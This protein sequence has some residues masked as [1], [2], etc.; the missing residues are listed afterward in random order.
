LLILY[1]KK[2]DNMPRRRQRVPTE[3]FDNYVLKDCERKYPSMD[4]LTPAQ[5]AELEKRVYKLMDLENNARVPF[6][7]ADY[8]ARWLSGKAGFE[9]RVL[10]DEPEEGDRKKKYFF[11]DPFDGDSMVIIKEGE[12]PI[13]QGFNLVACHSDA[14]CLRIK[15]SPIKIEW[16]EDEQ[17]F[18]LGVRLSSAAHGGLVYSQWPSQQVNL[19]GYFVDEK[20]NRQVI[21]IPGIIPD[22]S[23][24][25][26]HRE[27]EEVEDAFAPEETLEV[28]LGHTTLKETLDRFGFK[29]IDDFGFAKI[30]G[31]PTNMAL[32]ID[33][34][35]WR[36]LCA[37]GHDDRAC[38]FSAVS[39]I[40]K[41]RNPKLTSIVWIGDNEEVGDVSPSG[42]NGFVM[43]LVLD[44]LLRKHERNTGENI[45][46]RDRRRLLLMSSYLYADVNIAPFGK[47]STKMDAINAPKLGFGV[48]IGTAPGDVSSLYFARKLKNIALQGK[49]RGN[50]ICPQ[51]VGNM[52]HQNLQDTWAYDQFGGAFLNQI[53]QWN[54]SIG[55][56]CASTHSPNEVICPGDEYAL[57][58]FLTRF[59]RS[60]TGLEARVRN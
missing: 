24:H 40:S 18:T 46:E 37:Y 17:Y 26:D 10:L 6:Q 4:C 45:S 43:D 13:T 59:F 9:E 47:D 34:K 54:T 16:N 12:L 32:P 25:T 56:P 49:A 42:A 44:Y 15:P 19:I 51:V 55:I 39:A 38:M 3:T 20:F 1:T 52:Y 2:V 60:N 28:I 31:V 27:G 53:G 33:E 8:N 36:L 23:A 57:F 35:T 29:S 50:N 14:P 11:R 41:V 22:I 58:Q 7:V 21:E 48:N 5:Q 30:F